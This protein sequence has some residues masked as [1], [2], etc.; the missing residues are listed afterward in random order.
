[1]AHVPFVGLFHVYLRV[2][3][4]NALD[5]VRYVPITSSQL[6]LPFMY[7]SG[8]SF[9]NIAIV[10]KNGSAAHMAI[11]LLFNTDQSYYGIVALSLSVASNTTVTC[12]IA[13]KAW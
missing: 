12:M 10:A 8:F 2:C 5:D 3:C 9:A 4:G 6:I 7:S 11:P 13:Y 1:M